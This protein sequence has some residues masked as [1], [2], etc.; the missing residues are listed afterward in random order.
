MK[1]TGEWGEFLPPTMSL[2]GYNETVAQEH[3]PLK[4]E[5]AIKCNLKW[6]D[7]VSGSYKKETVLFDE[8]TD[9]IADITAQIF[10][11]NECG[12]NYKITPQELRFYK[13]KHLPIP[14]KCPDCR[15]KKRF[16]LRNPLKLWYRQCMHE[17]DGG[18]R[19]PTKFYTAYSPKKP[20]IVY[21]EN[22][23]HQAFN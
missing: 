21:C 19:C 20:E 9:N 2:F 23:Y 18:K 1:K 13:M 3:F 12:K 16:N 11:C 14:R 4:P 10:A 6:N 17:L 8:M 15:H 7:H 5:T 22:C